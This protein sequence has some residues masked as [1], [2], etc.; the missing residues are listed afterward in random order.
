MKRSWYAHVE[1]SPR[2]QQRLRQ[3]VRMKLNHWT[4]GE[5]TADVMS[6]LNRLL[7]GWA[8]YFHY[9]QSS[10]V[11]GKLNWQVRDRLRRWLWR[12]HGRT[13][14]LWSDY[15]DEQLVQTY[16]L[17]SLPEWVRWKQSAE[18]IPNALR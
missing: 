5:P 17:W 14:A 13:R 6:R 4:L 11:M 2:S 15:P 7:R 10:R 1:G 8:G 3:A 16:G 12:K 18:V 9:R